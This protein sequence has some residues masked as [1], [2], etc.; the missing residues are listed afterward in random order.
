MTEPCRLLSLP[1][2]IKTQIWEHVLT[3]NT[4]HIRKDL[5]RDRVYHGICAYETPT[6]HSATEIRALQSEDRY[7]QGGSSHSIPDLFEPCSSKRCSRLSTSLLRTCRQLHKET[8]M[9]LYQANN[10]ALHDP[11]ALELFL[12]NLSISQANAIE[13]LTLYYAHPPSRVTPAGDKRELRHEVIIRTRLHGL[14]YLTCMIDFERFISHFSES[15]KTTAAAAKYLRFFGPPYTTFT[16]ATVAG[17]N[18]TPREWEPEA[19]MPLW[20]SAEELERW[21]DGGEKG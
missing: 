5:Y 1:P 8:A 19:T 2:E 7:C 14:K 20:I 4:L 21:A 16:R 13:K 18:G 3:G 12:H 11:S 6:T 10:F 9:L 17:S 15:K